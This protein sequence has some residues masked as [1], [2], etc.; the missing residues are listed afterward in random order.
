MDEPPIDRSDPQGAIAVPQQFVRID[1]TI[2]EQSVPVGC[3]SK[4]I[5]L[6]FVPS[7]LHESGAVQR[8]Q[9]PSVRASVQANELS[10]CFIASGRPRP[11]SPD[12][13]LGGG[14]E[15]PG[16]VLVHRPH[17]SAESAIL[18]RAR[19]AAAPYGAEPANTTER[20]RP[21]R[22]LTV[23]EQRCHELIMEC[24]RTG[25]LAVPQDYESAKRADPQTAVAGDEQAIDVLIGQLL[26]RGWLPGEKANPIE[27]KQP[28]FGPQPEIPIWGLGHRVDIAQREP[29]SH[30]PRVVRVLADLQGRAQRE[31][32]GVRG[33]Q[34][35]G[36]HQARDQRASPSR[37]LFHGA[38]PP[39]VQHASVDATVNPSCVC[40]TTIRQIAT[41]TRRAPRRCRTCGAFDQPGRA[42]PSL[43]RGGIWIR[44]HPRN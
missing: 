15:R 37:P 32:A 2:G 31:R 40:R 19:S 4:G 12:A 14:P 41:A 13:G 34:Y 44:C 18:S 20:S 43:S 22:A 23:F 10:R 17:G 38:L 8:H 21:H 24:R 16:A 42:L 1:I 26:T 9:Q 25:K 28:E 6:D 5:A 39:G 3:V 33:E 27:A 29:I 35:P 30:R 7:E 11:Q 36:Q